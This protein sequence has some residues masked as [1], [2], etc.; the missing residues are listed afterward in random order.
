L[1]DRK[2][3]PEEKNKNTREEDREEN[4]REIR[5]KRRREAERQMSLTF[6]LRELLEKGVRVV[7]IQW[8]A[9]GLE[10]FLSK[11]HI[12]TDGYY[13]YVPKETQRV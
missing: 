13:F 1:Q 11:P 9:V 10:D 4:R 7:S 3:R 2:E 6:P 8:E 5:K 12:P